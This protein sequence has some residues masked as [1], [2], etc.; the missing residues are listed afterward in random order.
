ME[1]N[2]FVL[3][4]YLNNANKYELRHNA[5]SGWAKDARRKSLSIYLFCVADTPSLGF[6]FCSP[7]GA[8]IIVIVTLILIQPVG[9][10]VR[11]EQTIQLQRKPHFMCA[12]DEI[13]LHGFYVYFMKS[14]N[15]FEVQAIGGESTRINDSIFLSHLAK[16]LCNNFHENLNLT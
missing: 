9:R 4:V 3:W 13:E 14:C 7:I 5:R 1:C 16:L 2:R 15:H 8:N 10:I 11:S 12:M 6:F